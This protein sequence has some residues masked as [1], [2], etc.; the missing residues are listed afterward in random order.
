[1]SYVDTGLGNL[2]ILSLRRAPAPRPAAGASLLNLN[3]FHPAAPRT[4]AAGS[5][6]LNIL[7]LRPNAPG[8]LTPPL[9]IMPPGAGLPIAAVVPAPAQP[10]DPIT[11]TSS[12]DMVPTSATTQ[13]AD[14]DPGVVDEAAPP[15][16]TD[17]P[18]APK[19]GLSPVLVLGS[20]AAL[21]FLTRR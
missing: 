11:M 16:A 21:F 9:N 17:A 5:G 2:N 7:T 6:L 3:L 20:L 12:M 8:R 19:P 15:A 13:L 1:V 10:A 18:A 14:P 4:P